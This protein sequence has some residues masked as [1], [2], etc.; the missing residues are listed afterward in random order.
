MIVTSFYLLKESMACEDDGAVATCQQGP[1]L[2]AWA[3]HVDAVVVMSDKLREKDGFPVNKNE[4]VVNILIDNH[5][6]LKLI[7]GDRKAPVDPPLDILTTRSSPSM[8]A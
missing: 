5:N 4:R 7:L 8:E 1:S 3:H 2:E 6:T